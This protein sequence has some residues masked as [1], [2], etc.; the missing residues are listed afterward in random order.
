[1][2]N[3]QFLTPAKAARGLGSAK[4]GTIIIFASAFQPLRWSF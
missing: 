4:S 3:S 1:M 2:S